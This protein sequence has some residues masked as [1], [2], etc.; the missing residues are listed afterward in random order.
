[1]MSYLRAIVERGKPYAACG[2]W[3]VDAERL[4]IA[5]KELPN[6][7]TNAEYLHNCKRA[8]ALSNF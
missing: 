5:V 4:V 1:M 2:E 8:L 6:R 7:L 3:E